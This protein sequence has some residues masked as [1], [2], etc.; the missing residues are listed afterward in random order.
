MR[1]YRGVAV[2]TLCLVSLVG[3]TD[4]RDFSGRWTGPRV[5]DGP[6]L[7]VGLTGSTSAS[8]TVE[9]A[10]LRSFRAQLTT[11]DDVFRDA[12]IQPVAG[13]QAD[14]LAGITW[15]GSPARVYLAF[16]PA[17]DGGGDATALVALY[18]DD[19]IELR[20]LRGGPSPLYAVF[21]LSRA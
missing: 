13:A 6:P 3:C 4:L 20:L 7:R 2:A 17:S 18:E 19:R 9:R 15:D 14:V 10:T 12:V 1:R 11:S 21:S 8:L 16:V 5:G